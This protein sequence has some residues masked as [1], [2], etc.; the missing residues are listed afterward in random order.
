MEDTT[1]YAWKHIPLSASNSDAADYD[2]IRGLLFD[3]LFNTNAT[4]IVVFSPLKDLVKGL[5]SGFR[6]GRMIIDE[7]VKQNA[8]CVAWTESQGSVYRSVRVY[9]SRGGEDLNIRGLTAD[10][11]IVHG[12][13]MSAIPPN[14]RRDYIVPLLDQGCMDFF[15]LMSEPTYARWLEAQE[16]D[17][18]KEDEAYERAQEEE[19][20]RAQGASAL[21][22][23]TGIEDV[24]AMTEGVMTEIRSRVRP[25]DG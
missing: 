3:I 20:E 23:M 7:V 15:L 13:H 5:V 16:A 25:Y 12:P 10:T 1:E 4:H 18:A 21:D 22:A 9:G 8:E 11:L 24:A 6:S 14:L 17:I 2:Q 19:A